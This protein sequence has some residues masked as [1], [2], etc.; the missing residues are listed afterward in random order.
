MNLKHTFKTSIIGL[1]TNKVRSLLTILGI[2]IG[3]SAIII[4]FSIG[5]GAENL[6]LNEL[7]G[8]ISSKTS[9]KN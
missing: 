4:I 5:K 8:I 9:N 2:V 7:G 1:K 3:I 6:I